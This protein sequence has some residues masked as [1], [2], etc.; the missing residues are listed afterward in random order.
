MNIAFIRSS[1]KILDRELMDNFVA[2]TTDISIDIVTE[3]LTDDF[4][5]KQKQPLILLHIGN[6]FSER[7][8]VLFKKFRIVVIDITTGYYY[9]NF[10]RSSEPTLTFTSPI[11]KKTKTNTSKYRCESNSNEIIQMIKDGYK[12]SV[13]LEKFQLDYCAYRRWRRANN[14]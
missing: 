10:S 12:D 2:K 14:I 11:K 4:F 6:D 8:K 3:E 9:S 7:H 13:I 5:A 1:S